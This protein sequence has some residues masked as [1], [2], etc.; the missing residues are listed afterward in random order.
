AWAYAVW[1]S[2][3]APDLVGVHCGARRAWDAIAGRIGGYRSFRGDRLRRFAS[4]DE[5]TAGYLAEE[6][7]AFDTGEEEDEDPSAWFGHATPQNVA[8]AALLPAPAAGGIAGEFGFLTL[9]DGVDSDYEVTVAALR[10][11]ADA[12]STVAVVPSGR[13]DTAYEAMHLPAWDRVG[14]PLDGQLLSAEIMEAPS[15]L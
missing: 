2:P 4:E 10:V 7:N 12:L 14:S 5:A 8:A 13:L 3:A 6:E 15:A 1:A 11:R 9:K